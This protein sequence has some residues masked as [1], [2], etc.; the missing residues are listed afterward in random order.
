[1]QIPSAAQQLS[2]I[3]PLSQELLGF[4]VPS[5]SL[6]LE[7]QAGYRVRVSLAFKAF[8]SNESAL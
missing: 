6:L 5:T 3:F 7:C 8:L 2:R 4:L 1:M